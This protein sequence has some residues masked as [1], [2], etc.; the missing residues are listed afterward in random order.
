M[1]VNFKSKEAEKIFNGEWSKRFPPEIQKRVRLKLWA[2]NTALTINELRTP[3]SNFLEQLY[4]N[5]KEQYSIRI[6]DQWRICFEWHS[7]NAYN[8]EIVDYH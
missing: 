5:R 1:I 7:D 8:I 4:G 2:L 3:R 6:N